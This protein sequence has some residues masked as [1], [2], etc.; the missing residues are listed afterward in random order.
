MKKDINTKCDT[1]ARVGRSWSAKDV[2]KND[3]QLPNNFIIG[4]TNQNLEFNSD[5]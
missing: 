4:M 5:Q 2:E 1:N 3:G